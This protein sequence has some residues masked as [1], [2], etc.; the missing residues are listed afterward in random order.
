MDAATFA[1]FLRD[2]N[3]LKPRQVAE[4]D[5]VLAEARERAGAVLALETEDGG[6]DAEPPLCPRCGA[7]ASQRWGTTRTGFQRR[8]CVGCGATFTARTGTVLAGLRRPGAVA[9]LLAM[10]VGNGALGSAESLSCRKIGV[11]LGITR[12]T[13]WRWR[14]VLLRALPAALV[15]TPVFTGLVEMDE[16]YQMESRKASREWMRHA[17]DPDQHPQPN[18]PQWH[19]W[20]KGTRPRGLNRRWHLP[21]LTTV[22]RGGPA[23]MVP[24]TRPTQ[25]VLAVTM[26]GRIAP[27]AHLH[28]DGAFA[29]ERFAQ[30]A[31]L[32]HTVC[33]AKQ[34]NL[35]VRPS[36]HINTV[37]GVHAL[38]R[39]FIG[40][41]K[42]P[43]SKNLAAYAAWFTLLRN[44]GPTPAQILRAVA[45]G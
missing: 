9:R 1:R 24:I 43:A 34:P 15:Q 39:R 12:T 22:Q 31:G 3:K 11:R 45:R 2:A 5:R 21:L 42:G 44:P 13:A 19:A 41:F 30:N 29:F 35:R 36:A 6:D 32:D 25:H 18:R 26:A 20:P 27:D 16:A 28:T 8:R 17:A 23:E 38:W 40:A 7:L 37:N 4:V 33:I 14:M 10:M